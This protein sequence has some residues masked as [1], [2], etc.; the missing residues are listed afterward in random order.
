[1]WCARIIANENPQL[2]LPK[3]ASDDPASVEDHDLEERYKHLEPG[4]STWVQKLFF[5]CYQDPLVR[6]RHYFSM[7]VWPAS[8]SVSL[9]Q[10]TVLTYSA[11]LI[12]YLLTVGFSLSAITIAR[13]YTPSWCWVSLRKTL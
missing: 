12:T 10:M 6:L 3:S 8:I 11:T 5:V 9:L 2:R 1:M 4:L 7:D 13:V